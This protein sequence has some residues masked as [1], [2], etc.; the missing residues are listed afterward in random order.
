M[1]K[2]P[3]TKT[4]KAV[5]SSLEKEG[6]ALEMRKAGRTYD[7]I[8]KELGISIGGAYLLLKRAI[9][10]LEQRSIE[11]VTEYRRLQLERLDAMLAACWDKA[12]DGD[13]NAIDRVL[14]IEE[15]RSKLLGLDYPATHPIGVDLDKVERIVSRLQTHEIDITDASLEISKLGANMPEAMRIMLSKTPPVVIA[16]NL[17]MPSEAEL[18]QRALEAMEHVKWQLECFLPE[19]Q[20]EVIELKKELAESD[21]FAPD[22]DS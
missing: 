16:N 4:S 6:K 7:E 8:R 12:Q 18:D 2:R 1:K 20:Q 22:K 9:G 11:G 15:R 3:K 17:E 13:Y 19:R 10:R 14:K 5:I 21:S